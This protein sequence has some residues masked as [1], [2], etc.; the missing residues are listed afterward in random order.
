MDEMDEI[1]VAALKLLAARDYCEAELRRKLQARFGEIPETVIAHLKAK[2]FLNDRR[3]A[4]VYASRRQNRGQVRVRTELATRGV[5][6]EIIGEVLSSMQWPSLQEAVKAT[7][8]VLKL[9]HPLD[10]RQAARLFRALQRLGYE[11]GA[12]QEEV[13]QLHEQ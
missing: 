8:V 5:S 9:R 11:E 7:M 10:R 12:I 3:Y 13:E 2:N 4:Q 1:G 6:P